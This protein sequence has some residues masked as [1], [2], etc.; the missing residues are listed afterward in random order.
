ISSATSGSVIRHVGPSFPRP[1][2]RPRELPDL[3]TAHYKGNGFLYFV[4]CATSSDNTAERKGRIIREALR[5]ASRNDW[6]NQR[7]RCSQLS[8]R[9][10]SHR[11]C[12]SR[13]RISESFAASTGS[14]HSAERSA[15][16][17]Q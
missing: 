5:L 12:S 3:W 16:L 15:V 13:A 2:V 4:D 8:D 17:S 11:C 14:R 7:N 9:I 10:R 6:Q 1:R